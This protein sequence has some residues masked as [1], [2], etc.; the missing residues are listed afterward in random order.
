MST[1]NFSNANGNQQVH[2]NGKNAWLVNPT[3]GDVKELFNRYVIQNLK[4]DGVRS[5]THKTFTELCNQKSLN[6]LE[7]VG[8]FGFEFFNH[9]VGLDND[10]IVELSENMELNKSIQ[11]V[12]LRNMAVAEKEMHNMTIYFSQLQNLVLEN[13]RIGEKTYPNKVLNQEDLEEAFFRL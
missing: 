11:K 13:V 2:I 6:G 10:T 3:D 12:I 7:L 9:Y 1:V 4:I 5:L 8:Y